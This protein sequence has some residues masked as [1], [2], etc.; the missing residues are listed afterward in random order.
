MLRVVKCRFGPLV[1]RYHRGEW[2]TVDNPQSNK[3]VVAGLD[4]SHNGDY[5]VGYVSDPL[6]VIHGSRETTHEEIREKLEGLGLWNDHLIPV[7]LPRKGENGKRAWSEAYKTLPRESGRLD[8]YKNVIKQEVDDGELCL[9]S[10]N[11]IETYV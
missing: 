9:E 11:D 4:C 6:L 7:Y 2:H 8:H 5:K 10:K 3:G 1:K